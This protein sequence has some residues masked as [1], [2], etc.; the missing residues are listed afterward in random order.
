[1]NIPPELVLKLTIFLNLYFLLLT[2]Y[3]IRYLHRNS[4]ERLPSGGDESMPRVS[5]I[6]PV[7][8]EEERVAACVG[9]LLDQT[10]A[11]YEIIVVDDNS[12][13]GTRGILE[14]IARR[15]ERLRVVV[16]RPLQPGWNGKSFA[17]SQ[18]V[19]VADGDYLLF[20]DAD[21]V[22][23]PESISWAL[24][25]AREHDADL[26][27][28]YVRQQLGNL[29]ELI[30]VP[31]MFIM[32][33]LLLPLGLIPRKNSSIVSFAIGQFMICK[34][35]A[36]RAIGTY[37]RFRGS[38]V[39]DVSMAR[40]MKR[41]GYKTLFLDAAGHISCRMYDGFSSAFRGIAKS[42]F[43]AINSSV[44][45]LLALA[46][47]I[48]LAIVYPFYSAMTGV[49]GGQPLL[50]PSSIPVGIFLLTWLAKMHDRHVSLLAVLLY[51]VTFVCLIVVA[52]YSAA[53]TGFGIGLDWKGRLVTADA[54][55]DRAGR[56]DS[57]I[58]CF[59]L[60]YRLVSSIV[61]IVT[62]AVVFLFAKLVLGLRVEGREHLRCARDRRRILI[63]NHVLYLDCAMVG[64]AI[65]PQRTYFSALEETFSLPAV[66]HLIRLLGAF[67]LPRRNTLRRIEGPVEQMF[68]MGR[69]VHFFPEGELRRL[70]QE[71]AEFKAGAFFLACL[72]EALVIP[73]TLVIRDRPIVGHFLPRAFGV[74][75]VIQEALDA[76]D[77]LCRYS[78]QQ[79][80]VQAM[81]DEARDRM[82]RLLRAEARE[83]LT[84][85]AIG[86]G[87]SPN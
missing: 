78:T 85:R 67:P 43:G 60:L 5:V 1:M 80:A 54:A 77:Y 51:P 48:V 8:N 22:H 16:G 11:N 13:D 49:L 7:R 40:E 20:T 87:S 36:F 56:Q 44:V 3:N 29:G 79:A 86:R 26:V 70:S 74:K 73:V 33:A 39:E 42:L 58:V 59:T 14:D 84:T 81:Q 68:S 52:L 32:T 18:G 4:V 66:G 17:C 31:V 24:Q 50:S 12:E 76:R 25:V 34:S 72:H 23:S 21:T 64:C 75:V 82:N 63:S 9:S 38:V 62:L 57:A 45:A 65:F 19:A 30:L 27:S 2:L 55:T 46:A 47:I 6:L 10:Y 53:M 69:L 37:E 61:Y 15:N 41:S 71:T 28:A 83:S 35:D